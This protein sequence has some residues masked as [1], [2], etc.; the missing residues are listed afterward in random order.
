MR[1]T[2]LTPVTLACLSVLARAQAPDDSFSR[3]ILEETVVTATRTEQTVF[4]VPYTAHVIDRADFIERRNVR[5]FPDALRDIPGVMVQRTAYGQASPFIRGFT[6]FRTLALI[7]GIRLN[8]ATFREGPNQYWGTIDQYTIDR[9]DVVKGPSSV[10]YGS[11]A[12][13]GTVNAISRKP[14]LLAAAP[15]PDGKATID[16]KTTKS[17]LTLAPSGP[18]FHGAAYY[19]YATA[20]NSHTARGE[21][22]AALSE[23]LGIAGGLTYRNYDDLR[24]GSVIGT[25]DHTGYDEISGDISLLWRPTDNVDVTLAFQRFEQNNAPRWHS[26]IYSKSFDGSAVGTDLRRDLD[27]LREL[28]YARIEARELA[29]WL[30]KATLTLSFHRQAEEQDRIRDTGR[31][32]VEGFQ[33]DQYGFLLNFESPSPI[34]TFSYGVEYYHDEVNSWGSRWNADG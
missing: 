2:T 3:S 26:T 17:T 21:F 1:K 12:I 5:T 15:A 7:D 6:G 9:I 19:R 23:R 30:S 28:G 14:P 25:Q 13:G 24:G 27:Q 33:D 22:S 16:G 18:E 10:L 29:D 8:N 20:E 4:D 31:R 11:D 32:D 34:G